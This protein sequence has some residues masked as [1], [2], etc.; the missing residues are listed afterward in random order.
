MCLG[1][2]SVFGALVGGVLPY[3]YVPGY[4]VAGYGLVPWQTSD[5]KFLLIKDEQEVYS[6]FWWELETDHTALPKDVVNQLKKECSLFNKKNL[7][8]YIKFS[9]SSCSINWE[10]PNEQTIFLLNVGD[11]LSSETVVIK[12]WLEY[13]KKDIIIISYKKLF[14]AWESK[15]PS[16]DNQNAYVMELDSVVR[17]NI[18]IPKKVLISKQFFEYIVWR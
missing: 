15:Q 3:R 10:K 2:Q 6:C 13:Y 11:Y 5:Y 7:R 9:D 18:I 14:A 8:N 17:N 12:N 16:H 4:N 1:G